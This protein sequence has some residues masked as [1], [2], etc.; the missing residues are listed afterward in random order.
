M[1]GCLCHE[2][3]SANHIALQPSRFII[4]YYT[5]MFH[6]HDLCSYY[7]IIYCINTTRTQYVAIIHFKENS[8]ESIGFIYNIVIVNSL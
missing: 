1:L 7:Y 5:Y 6:K 8:E 3:D 2:S 4:V